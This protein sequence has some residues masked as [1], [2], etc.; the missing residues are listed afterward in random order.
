MTL[1]LYHAVFIISGDAVASFNFN[2]DLKLNYY[3]LKYVRYVTSALNTFTLASVIHSCRASSKDVYIK[4]FK[5]SGAQKWELQKLGQRC[6]L[7]H[8]T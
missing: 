8:M 3:L 5:C 2:L 4:A 7:L 1:Y 6:L